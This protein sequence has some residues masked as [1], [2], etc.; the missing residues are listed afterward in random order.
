MPISPD[1]NAYRLVNGEGDGLPGLTVDRYGDYPDGADLLH[2]LEKTPET[3]D[4]GAGGT[5]LTGRDLRKDPA[6]KDQG[7]GVGKRHQEV[8]Q[9]PG[10]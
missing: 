2:R 3:G 5:P 1:T 6:P 10:G 4:P 9:P 8:R 7:A